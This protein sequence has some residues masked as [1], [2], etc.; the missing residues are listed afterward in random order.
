MF[1]NG[2]IRPYG[3]VDSTDMS[4][5]VRDFI[6][7]QEDAMP[8]TIS[9]FNDSQWMVL[10]IAYRDPRLMKL[11]VEP[12]AEYQSM[13][14]QLTALLGKNYY[15]VHSMIAWM[16]PSSEISKHTDLQRIYTNTRRLHVQLLQNPDAYMTSYAGD[17]EY[18]FNFKQGTVYELNNR[19]YHGGKNNSKD[20][21]YALLVVDF[22]LKSQS[23]SLEDNVI[24]DDNL[25]NSDQLPVHSYH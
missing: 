10:D 9:L 24:K 20:N 12:P 18:R 2:L 1:F 16:P 15:V 6:H 5:F 13:I 11:Y 23:F 22:A 4:E 7:R 3:E 8:S 21:Y 14:Q 19:I 25:L 17:K